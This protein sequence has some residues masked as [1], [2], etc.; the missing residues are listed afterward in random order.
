[1][2]NDR[3]LFCYNNQFDGQV[4]YTYECDQ[5]VDILETVYEKLEIPIAGLLVK[6]STESVLNGGLLPE[7]SELMWGWGDDAAQTKGLW[8][9]AL[10][11]HHHASSAV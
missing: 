4:K 1:M 8:R 6:M 7:L 3:K 11:R 9:R 2:L 10:V 5:I